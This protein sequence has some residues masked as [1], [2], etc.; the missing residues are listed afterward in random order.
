MQNCKEKIELHIFCPSIRNVS[1]AYFQRF[2]KCAPSVIIWWC[3]KK[4]DWIFLAE[5]SIASDAKCKITIDWMK[6]KVCKM[7][8][9]IT[10]ICGTRLCFSNRWFHLRFICLS[11]HSTDFYLH[12]LTFS[13]CWVVYIFIAAMQNMERMC[14]GKKMKENCHLQNIW[15]DTSS[16]VY[17]RLQSYIY[18]VRMHRVALDLIMQCDPLCMHCCISTAVRK[19]R[20]R[21]KWWTASAWYTHSLALLCCIIS[22][23]TFLLRLAKVGLKIHNRWALHA[24]ALP[25]EKDICVGYS[26]EVTEFRGKVTR[27]HQQMVFR[28]KNRDTDRDRNSK[29]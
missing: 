3:S 29:A 1:V 4:F 8:N 7:V 15:F 20:I 10:V 5:N 17:W 26:S 18:M 16:S 23:F 11:V 28:R 9:K 14:G 13:L 25:M 12:I 19:R 27:A 2:I 22:Y 21:Q 24:A 6:R